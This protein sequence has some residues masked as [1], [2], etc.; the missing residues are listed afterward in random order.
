MSF[1]KAI[2]H[3]SLSLEPLLTIIIQLNALKSTAQNSNVYHLL[4]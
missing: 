3:L 2:T 4:I 1:W